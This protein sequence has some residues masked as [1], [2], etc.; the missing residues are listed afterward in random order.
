MT[1]ERLLSEATQA[2]LVWHVLPTLVRV[3]WMV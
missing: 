3:L 1:E 2:S